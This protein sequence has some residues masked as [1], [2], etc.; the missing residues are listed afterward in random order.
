MTNLRNCEPKADYDTNFDDV[1]ELFY[2]P[3]LSNCSQYD[4]MA[5][6]FTSSSLSIS[7][8]GIKQLIQNEGKMRLIISPYISKNDEELFNRLISEPGIIKG[9]ISDIL[10]SDVT[11]EFISNENT[12]ALGWMLLNGFLEIHVIVVLKE[13]GEIMPAEEI[14]ESGLFHNKIGIMKDDENNVI[15]FS[16]SI[17]E[18]FN[19]WNSNIESFDVFCSWEDGRKH[20]DPKIERFETYWKLGTSNRGLTLDLPTAV[21]NKWTRNIPQEKEKLSIFKR[22]TNNIEARDYQQIAINNWKNNNYKGIFNMATGT[23]KTFTALLGVKQL[24]DDSKKAILVV[25]VP[26]NHLIANPWLESIN[27]LFCNENLN[28]SIIEAFDNSSIWK[29]KEEN[30]R[31]DYKLGEINLLIFVTTYKTLSGQLFIETIERYKGTKILIADEVHN[32]GSDTFRKGLMEDYQ[33]RLGLSATPS[34]YLDDEGTNFIISY[35]DKEVYTFSLEKAINTINPQTGKSYLT[36]YEYHPIFVTLTDE[37]I[38]EYTEMSKQIAIC[39]PEKNPT[40]EQLKRRSDLLIKRSRI[41]KNASNKLIVLRDMIPSFKKN[42]FFDHSLIYCSDGHYPEDNS[43]KII[44]WIVSELNRN[45]IVNSPFT[46]EEN[47]SERKRILSSFSNGKIS[48]LVAIKCLDEGVDVPSTRNAIIIAS[49]ANPRE[50][51]QRRGRVLRRY[52]GKEFAVIYD[53]FVIPDS[54]R[55]ITNSDQSIFD[56]EYRRFKEFADISLN[57]EENYI[58]IDKIINKFNLEVKN[59]R[60]YQ[61]SFA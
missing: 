15:V 39:C 52:P 51:I 48:T 58:L 32:A 43:K 6:F 23:G 18:T 28:I 20:I 54:N 24:I 16:G 19:A 11:E 12:E 33:Y 1:V 44:N 53:F 49:S 61:S 45:D 26:Y 10:E 25:A 8:K 7:A 37:E 57:K 2:I 30:T 60:L 9:E 31:I 3:C 59:E 22:K 38:A 40:E 17:N 27:Q 46:F 35:F 56:G 4:R 42:G 55:P 21:K 34:R 5:G 41:T 29:H 36:P 13:N 47:S 50:Y 14:D